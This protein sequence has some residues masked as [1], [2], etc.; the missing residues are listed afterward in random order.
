MLQ[1]GERM[2]M[3]I[4]DAQLDQTLANIAREQGATIADMRSQLK[5][6]VRAFKPIEKK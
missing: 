6:V 2:G 5:P 3:Q 1:L 4:S